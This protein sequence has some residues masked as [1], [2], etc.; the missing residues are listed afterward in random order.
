MDISTWNFKGYLGKQISKG[1]QNL[2][3]WR[4]MDASATWSIEGHLQDFGTWKAIE[5]FEHLKGNWSRS[6]WTLKVFGH[7]NTWELET[8]NALDAS[9]FR[10]TWPMDVF[11]DTF[12]LEIFSV[13]YKNAALK[14]LHNSWKKIFAVV[15]F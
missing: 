3:T 7:L 8:H 14:N 10:R 2:C 1:F 12:R 5:A 15:S 6:T 13:F 9:R 4:H 11:I